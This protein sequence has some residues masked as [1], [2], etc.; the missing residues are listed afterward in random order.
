MQRSTVSSHVARALAL[1]LTL[2][3]CAHRAPH[4]EPSRVCTTPS[5][6]ARSYSLTASTDA[7][8]A[9]LAS[10]PSLER[11]ARSCANPLHFERPIQI[12][13]IQPSF[14]QPPR[15]PISPC[16]RA[17]AERR[18]AQ[19]LYDAF[20]D[21][22]D[23]AQPGS[24][25]APFRAQLV[26]MLSHQCFAM[27]AFSAEL[28][29][30][31][32]TESLRT[33]WES[34]GDSWASGL[35]ER[36]RDP[37]SNGQPGAE[38]IWF[39]PT[40]RLSLVAEDH[41]GSPIAPL[42][43]P[44]RDEECGRETTTFLLRAQRLLRAHDE[45]EFVRRDGMNPDADRRS[46]EDWT[47]Y[48]ERVARSKPELER[49]A[50]WQGCASSHMRLAQS[51]L[52]IG[53]F[54]A[55]SGW[56]VVEGRYGRYEYCET[57][58]AFHLGSGSVYEARA[59][60]ARRRASQAS[61]AGADPVQL[62]S[63]RASPEALRDATLALILAPFVTE[64]AR[65]SVGL[66]LPT[67]VRVAAT[68]SASIDMEGF[69]GWGSSDQT[70]LD[71]S[72]TAGGCERAKGT[73]IMPESSKPGDDVAAHLLAIA[74]ESFDE[75]DAPSVEL[76]RWIIG[77]TSGESEREDTRAMLRRRLRERFGRE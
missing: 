6:A 59:C 31:N 51:A 40:E 61:D 39:M 4:T 36:P 27:A 65:E 57:I 3:A 14:W 74:D 58:R 21:A 37:S 71:W 53:R 44:A 64:N 73:V 60:A 1:A 76:P 55:P 5:E 22:I 2:V 67:G 75:R 20:N 63:G 46:N 70:A 34:G 69:G 15:D 48:C 77:A 30:A 45:S 35:L 72:W 52:P 16:A 32:T 66:A 41:R 18:E 23:R 10:A 24:D 13:P 49:F 9:A 56:L 33:W 8:A 54:R 38:R 43:C 47:Q 26:A 17:S 25:V 19:R 68:R 11:P 42:L 50:W 12:S 29:S 28:P 62:R 7:G